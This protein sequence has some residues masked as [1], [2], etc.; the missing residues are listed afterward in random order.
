MFAFYPGFLDTLTW[1]YTL[2]ETG[3]YV[4]AAV[5]K[6]SNA[7]DLRRH[8]SGDSSDSSAKGAA[9]GLVVLAGSMALR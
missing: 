5:V 3:N 4:L 1:V 8:L 2:T 9:G 7:E 6:S